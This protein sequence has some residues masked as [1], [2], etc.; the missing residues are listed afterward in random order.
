MQNGQQC[1]VTASKYS[2]SLLFIDFNYLY[3]FGVE[4]KGLMFYVFVY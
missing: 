1:H 4:E 3:H 2:Q